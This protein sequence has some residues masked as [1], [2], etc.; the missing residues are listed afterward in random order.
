MPAGL[1]S[2]LL[3]LSAFFT[4]VLASLVLGERI[5]PQQWTGMAVAGAGLAIIL[6]ATAPAAARGAW[7]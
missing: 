6:F 3:Q 2:L 5:G 1:A 4:I 7:R